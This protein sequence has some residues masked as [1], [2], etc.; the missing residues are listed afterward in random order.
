MK[1]LEPLPSLTE[2]SFYGHSRRPPDAEIVIN[3]RRITIDG[4]ALDA[5]TV[6]MLVGHEPDSVVISLRFGLARHFDPIDPIV[7]DRQ[8]QMNFR[9]FPQ[10]ALFSLLVS[11]TRWDWGAPTISVGEVRDIAGL[12]RQNALVSGDPEQI[13]FDDWVIDLATLTIPVL[14]VRSRASRGME[15]GRAYAGRRHLRE[16]E[17][18]AVAR[19]D[20]PAKAWDDRAD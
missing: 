15:R 4:N 12:D 6:A 14:K 19:T 11:D 17:R 13:L 7:L 10:G 1:Q 5:A 18:T 16:S 8:T 20:A 3:G 2:P 9:T